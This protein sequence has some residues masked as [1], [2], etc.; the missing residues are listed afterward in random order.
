[1]I[2]AQDP[3]LRVA[4]LEDDARVPSNSSIRARGCA[5]RG[6]EIFYA[7]SFGCCARRDDCL[8][9]SV[10]LERSEESWAQLPTRERQSLRCVAPPPFTQGRLRLVHLCGRGVEGA[11]P[12][13]VD[14]YRLSNCSRDIYNMAIVFSMKLVQTCVGAP[15]GRP[16]HK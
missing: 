1:M 10:I 12:Y 14:I 5:S 6:F 8:Q 4:P 9:S 3:S 13:E 16:F 11:A 7:R 2:S 15:I